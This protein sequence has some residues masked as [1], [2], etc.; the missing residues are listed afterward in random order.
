M[1]KNEK[2]FVKECDCP[3][4]QKLWKPKFRDKFVDSECEEVRTIHEIFIDLEDEKRKYLMTVYYITK[5][6]YKGTKTVDRKNHNF[7]WL[8]SLSQIIVE[9]SMKK[10]YCTL[11]CDINNENFFCSIVDEKDITRVECSNEDG[12]EGATPEISAI[13]ALKEVI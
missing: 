11:D 1:T 9:I 4:I 5:G 8:P 3:E 13:K 12:F 2:L 10:F 6:G 7:I